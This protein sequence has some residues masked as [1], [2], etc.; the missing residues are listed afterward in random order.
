MRQARN[1]PAQE[2][3]AKTR[4]LNIWV[5]ADE[6]LFS[7]ASLARM[8]AIRARASTTSRAENA[9]SRSI[10]RAGPISRRWHRVPAAGSRDRRDCTTPLS[11]AAT[12]TRRRFW[13]RATPP[14]PAGRPRAIW[15]SRRATRP[16]SARSRTTFSTSASGS[17][18][19]C[20]A[21]DPWAATQLAQRL[22]AEGVPVFEFRANTQNFSEP[23]KELDAAMR[24]GRIEHD[25]NPVLEWCLGN[26]VGRYD[27]RGQCLSAQIA[28]GTEDRRRDRADHG[29]SPAA[30]R[31][32]RRARSTKPAGVV[33][34]G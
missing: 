25:G 4:H 33:F 22:I 16:T 11:R 21:Y 17:R 27:A 15:S 26:V 12:S 23:T 19:C 30:W 32:S 8:R 2:A 13:R 34:M 28:A 9:I 6:A 1:N 5:S 20:V 10:S 18:C 14:I 7:H 24:A 29:R 3:A 31:R